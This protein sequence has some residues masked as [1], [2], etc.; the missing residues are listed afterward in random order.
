MI[1]SILNNFLGIQYLVASDN[2]KRYSIAFTKGMIITV[3][4]NII[5]GIM[6]SIY[7]VAV[8]APVGEMALTVFLILSIR[9]AEKD[10]KM[11]S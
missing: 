11:I 9:N 7:G 10:N 2:Q 5:L 4:A 3:A 6:Y 8:A 1:L